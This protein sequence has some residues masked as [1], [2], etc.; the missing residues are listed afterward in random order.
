MAPPRSD[1]TDV[2]S[3]KNTYHLQHFFGWIRIQFYLVVPEPGHGAVEVDGG[4]DGHPDHRPV[5]E[6]VAEDEGGAELCR[7]R[8]GRDQ[9]PGI[10][11]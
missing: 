8:R 9:R 5:G 6:G 10:F 7:R 1:L 4:A 11:I 2:E 3:P